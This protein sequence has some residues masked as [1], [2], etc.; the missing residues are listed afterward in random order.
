MPTN[1]YEYMHKYYIDHRANILNTI[2]QKTT[3]DLCRRLVSVGHLP[4]HKKSNI[5]FKYRKS[6]KEL[7]HLE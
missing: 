4:V 6:L 5:C 2:K 7:T 1:S 3:W